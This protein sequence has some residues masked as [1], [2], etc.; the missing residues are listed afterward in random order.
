MKKL[1]ALALLAFSVTS[2]AWE[3]SQN[4]TAIVGFGPGS[5][6]E[7]SF[8]VVAAEIERTNPKVHFVIQNMPG[9]ESTISANYIAK[10]APDG[11]TLNVTGNLSTYVASEV[12]NSDMIQYKQND[13]LPVLSIGTSPLAIIA[14]QDSK[15]NNVTELVQYMKTSTQQVNIGSG[16][17]THHLLYLLLVDG[18]G[19]NPKTVKMIRYKGP[20]QV[21]S[22]VAGGHIELGILPLAVAAP[23]V[24]SNKVK[25]IGISGD[26]RMPGLKNTQLVKDV[27][28]GAVVMAMWNI[29]LPGN[30]PTPIVDWYVKTFQQALRSTAVKKYFDE[31]Y[32]VIAKDQDPESSA[33]GI[34][35]LRAKYVP[36]AHRLKDID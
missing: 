19:A 29:T 30:T 31:N 26:T 36:I 3:P 18:P 4:I 15:V 24:E 13:L 16:S 8:R 2:Y 5:G 9:A 22:D 1:I 35:A 25:L 6:N 10:A 20:A 11:Y 7:L 12:F 34:A 14:R 17:S 23:L 28:P 32:M 21:L 33:K 27:I